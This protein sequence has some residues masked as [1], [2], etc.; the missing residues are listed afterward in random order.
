MQNPLDI[1]ELSLDNNDKMDKWALVPL[2]KRVHKKK[3]VALLKSISRKNQE[4]ISGIMFEEILKVI[5]EGGTLTKEQMHA[6]NNLSK[7]E[8]EKILKASEKRRENELNE[9]INKEFR[10]V[11]Q[12]LLVTDPDI[13]TGLLGSGAKITGLNDQNQPEDDK[14]LD[15]YKDDRN[16][17]LNEVM[18][19]VIR[20]DETPADI[21]AKVREK[22][23]DGDH[24]IDNFDDVPEEVENSTEEK[25]DSE[26]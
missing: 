18:I 26:E 7:K 1:F 13:A 11:Y 12:K 8:K 16:Y 25:E 15:T 23:S 5:K 22:I 17:A 19:A 14:F 2:E 6:F 20:D 4:V 9:L 3:E 21:K 10:R 24:D